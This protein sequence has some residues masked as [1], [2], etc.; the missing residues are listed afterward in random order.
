MNIKKYFLFILCG[1]FLVS[2][3]FNIGHVKLLEPDEGRY[4]EIPREMVATQDLVTPRLNGLLYF[5]KPPLQYWATALSFKLF[6]YHEWTARLCSAV[7]GAATVLVLAVFGFLEGSVLIGVVSAAILMSSPLHIIMGHLNTLDMTLTFFLTLLMLA[8]CYLIKEDLTKKQKNYA[9]LILWVSAALGIL[10]KG[11]LVIAVPG[12]AIVI[13]CLVKRSFVLFKNLNYWWGPALF[14][15]MTCPWLILVC[16]KNPDFFHFFF[17]YE[18]FERFLTA[19]H[20]RSGPWWYFIPIIFGGFFPAT[21][22]LFNKKIKILFPENLNLKNLNLKNSNLF[23]IIW[24]ITFFVFFSISKSKLPPYVLP[25]LPAL[26]I[27]AS[28][29]VFQIK[30]LSLTLMRVGYYMFSIL[31]LIAAWY[32]RLNPG[33]YKTADIVKDFTNDLYIISILFIL[34]LFLEKL[35]FKK[36]N[37]YSRFVTLCFLGLLFFQSIFWSYEALSPS[38]SG[39]ALA[40]A[41]K[42]HLKEDIPIYAVAN[43]SQTAPFY[44]QRTVTLVSTEGE[45]AFGIQH[46]REGRKYI[47]TV[48]EFVKEWKEL[49]SGIGWSSKSIFYDVLKNQIECTIIFEDKRRVA[50]IKN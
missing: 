28:Q 49:P 40:Q 5:E 18:H 35:F 45:L 27:L 13:Y 41:I 29:V 36:N 31:G 2:W 44:I 25:I 42:P 22:L 38:A 19:T 24:S 8:I 32:L 12:L 14:L 17:I 3:F 30:D 34:F 9:N 50:F 37:F 10:T 26:A 33:K 39:Y 21:L 11:F 46:N 15:L 6:G 7:A 4:S 1:L 23:L 43:Y 47:P 48:E 16:K 20:D